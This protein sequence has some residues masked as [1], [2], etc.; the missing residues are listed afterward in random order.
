ML[1]RSPA[2]TSLPWNDGLATLLEQASAAIGR[3]DAR[4]SA[5]A[6][7]SAWRLRASWT[8][9]AAAL[10]LQGVEIDEI[11][12]FSHACAL[13]LPGRARLATLDDPFAALP[14]WQAKFVS[15][16]TRHW[17]E[18]LGALVAPDP[19]YAGP[20]LVRALEA[21]RQITIA[22]STI[23]AWLALPLL[24]QRLAVT[25]TLL[26]CL[27]VGEKRLRFGQPADEAVLRRLLKA[28]A[29]RAATGLERLDAIERDR[30][31]AARAIA[32]AARPGAL[33]QLAARFQ[34]TPIASPQAIARAFG[35]TIG[36][37]GKLLARAAEAGLVREVR[38]TQAW[39]LYLAP[40]LAVAFGLVAP[41]RG[42][43]RAEPPPLP[44]D[45]ALAEILR[46]FDDEMAAFDHDHP[47]PA[48]RA[49]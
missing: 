5:T 48:E 46:A 22:D 41:P 19:S 28:L 45:R 43:P 20:R 11:D 3:L 6:V 10:Q 1:R 31:R 7:A 17:R 32:G 18:D 16:A 13:P 9:Y 37:A 29:A 35:I 14:R 12:V 36:G 26:P 4:D 2:L 40:D 47:A 15:N 49:D 42:R 39:K 23:D 44:D 38:G 34:I 33:P 24:L 25:R 8:G 27:V 21:L 30:L